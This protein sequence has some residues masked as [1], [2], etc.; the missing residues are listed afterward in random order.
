M[1]DICLSGSFAFCETVG[2]V[3]LYYA[4]NA[5]GASERERGEREKWK[6]DLCRDGGGGDGVGGV[7]TACSNTNRP[8]QH[9]YYISGVHCHYDLILIIITCL[10]KISH[11]ISTIKMIYLMSFTCIIASSCQENT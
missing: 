7:F 11:L 9:I 10:L 2:Q 5:L 4:C 8:E 1:Q 3:Y 6:M